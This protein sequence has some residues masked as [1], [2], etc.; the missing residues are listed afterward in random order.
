MSK[1]VEL[2]ELLP[3]L[4][5]ELKKQAKFAIKHD[6]SSLALYHLLSEHKDQITG[7]TPDYFHKAFRQ[8]DMIGEHTDA[9]IYALLSKAPLFWEVFEEL[10]D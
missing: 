2:G 5:A 9:A 6:Y 4:E 8:I 3:K 1:N 7:L 10:Y